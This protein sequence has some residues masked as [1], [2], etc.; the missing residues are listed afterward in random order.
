MTGGVFDMLR[1]DRLCSLD[2]HR[3]G[4]QDGFPGCLDRTVVIYCRGHI[5][6][7]V[8]AL[9]PDCPVVTSEMV[10]DPAK[11]RGRKEAI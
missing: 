6:F 1:P 9:E 8:T 5:K 11:Q 4:G 2:V 7:L 3:E 10:L